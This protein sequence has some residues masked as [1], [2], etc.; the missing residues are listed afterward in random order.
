[1]ASLSTKT[2]RPTRSETMSRIGRSASGRLTAETAMPLSWSIVAGIPSPTASTPGRASR[3]SLDLADQQLDQLVLGLPGRGLALLVEGFGA[4]LGKNPDEH[5]R[6]PEIDPDRLA[7]AHGRQE[8]GR[9][10]TE[11]IAMIS[12][13]S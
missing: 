1:M 8:A 11:Y 12:S 4:G 6:A 2:G 13:L 3:A 10:M 7:A 9:R 5:L